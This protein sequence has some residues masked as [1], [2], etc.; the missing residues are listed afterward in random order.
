[1]GIKYKGFVWLGI[2]VED[3]ETAI[4]FYSNT[5]GFTMLGRKEH[6]AHFDAGNGSLLELFTEGKASTTPKGTEKQSTMTALLVDNLEKTKAVLKS[7]GV[8][9]TDNEGVFENQRWATMVDLEGNRIEIKQ[10]TK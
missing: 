10:I 3:I 4:E 6:Y 2:Y 1:M 5:L 8:R 9:F 7:R